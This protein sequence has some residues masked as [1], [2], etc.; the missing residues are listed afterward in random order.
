MILWDSNTEEEKRTVLD[1]FKLSFPMQIIDNIVEW[2]SQAMPPGKR[3][4]NSATILKL[5]GYLLALTRTTSRR[6][7]LFSE[8]DGLFPTPRFRTRFGL[9]QHRT[10]MLL[11][12]LRFYPLT[13]VD[14]NDKWSSVRRLIDV[15]NLRRAELFYPSW[16]IS[17]DESKSAWRGKDGNGNK[18]N[19]SQ[20]RLEL[21]LYV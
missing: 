18:I 21:Q 19:M 2:T 3:G 12:A 8:C 20:V 7:N 11:R 14:I 13:D 4:I 1:Y 15:F 16:Q 10:D 6:R 9:S 17:V 5:F